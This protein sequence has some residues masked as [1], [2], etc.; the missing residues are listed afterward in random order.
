MNRP[1]SV[2]LIVA[3]LVVGHVA[4]GQTAPNDGNASVEASAPGNAV[5]RRGIM[6][7][8]LGFL[9]PRG[10]FTPG[11]TLSFGYGVRGGVTLGPHGLFDVGAAFRSVAHDSRTYRDT[12]RVK[13]ML[14]ALTLN[15]R[16]MAPLRHA[17]PY[18]GG[19]LGA[20]YFGTEKSVERCCNDEGE[21]D[22]ELDELSLVRIRPTASARIGL[23]V[24]MADMGGSVLS[25][26]SLDLGVEDHYGKRTT[27]QIDG[28]GPIVR[29][30][31][32]YRVY[33]LGVSVRAR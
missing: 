5:L 33:S 17:R 3:L 1:A 14:R 2:A 22:W 20:A 24:D 6:G 4:S 21:R 30:G 28:S 15:G 16:I 32:S 12:I 11:H 18:V 10:D 7:A 8:E 29:T 31:T 27:Y 26:L 23:L 25:T 9:V 13:N 19:S